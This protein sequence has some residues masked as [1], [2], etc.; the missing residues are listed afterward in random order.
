LRCDDIAMA[1]NS[2]E[3]KRCQA[4]RVTME[5]AMRLAFMALALL[6][7]AASCSSRTG[8]PTGNTP[9]SGSARP[10]VSESQAR[11]ELSDHG[12]GSVFNLHPSG[13]SWAGSAV[14]SDGKPIIFQVNENGVAVV[15]P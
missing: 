6:S 8:S 1:R 14:D 12:Y 2:S 3:R 15:A 4:T 9:A 13:D 7:V 5:E 11:K 10:A